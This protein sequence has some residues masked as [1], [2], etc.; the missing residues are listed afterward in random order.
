MKPLEMRVL[1]KS[2][3]KPFMIQVLDGLVQNDPINPKPKF[4]VNN[5]N[6]AM[7][8]NLLDY[9]CRIEGVYGLFNGILLHGGVGNGKTRLLECVQAVMREF[10][11][12]EMEIFTAVYIRNNYYADH[13]GEGYSLKYKLHNY[14]FIAINDI[15]MEAKYSSGSNIIQEILF[16]RFEK[17]L[18]TH[19]TTNL[20]KSEFFKKYADSHGRMVDRYK[21]LFNYV[22]LDGQSF[23]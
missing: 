4:V 21:T 3:V 7:M 22:K 10:W 19:G 20:S 5:K 8:N 14:K 18:I 12:K 11:H 9:L 1:N 23:R 16:D 6:R 2:K 13:E 17:R 15:G